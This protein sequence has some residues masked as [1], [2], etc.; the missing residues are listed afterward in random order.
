[1]SKR[2][3]DPSF[4]PSRTSLKEFL[5]TPLLLEGTKLDTT[6]FP[7]GLPFP[8]DA[9]R[10]MDEED[11]SQFYS[12]PRI[13]VRHIDDKATARLIQWY[14]DFCEVQKPRVVVDLA[15]SW[16]SHLPDTVQPDRLLGVGLNAAELAANPR[17][18][19]RYVAD[20]NSSPD[21]LQ[22]QLKVEDG[23]VDFVKMDLSI[24]YMTRPVRLLES[25]L[26]C[27]RPGGSFACSFSNRM[28]ADKAVQMWL[29]GDC[30]LRAKIVGAYLHYS[31]FGGVQVHRVN[32]RLGD[33]DPLTVVVGFKLD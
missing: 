21:A 27:L 25:I 33:G 31:G 28:F 15:S 13:H 32:S 29:Y 3:E 11:D 20:L 7:P 17:L 1:M 26:T 22:S 8:P 4:V 5:A 14:G 10:R 12:F 2:H 19:E 16:I 9:F 24:D 23:S 30:S 18:D 6:N